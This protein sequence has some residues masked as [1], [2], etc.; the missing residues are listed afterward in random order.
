MKYVWDTENQPKLVR[1]HVQ[2]A[3]PEKLLIAVYDANKPVYYHKHLTDTVKGKDMFEISLPLTPKRA[4]FEITRAENA[5]KIIPD[6]G[7]SGIA[8]SIEELPFKRPC[9]FTA[10]PILNSFMNFSSWFA[11]NAAILSA[12]YGGNSSSVYR[13]VNGKFQIRYFQSIR[14]EQPYLYLGDA[15]L[16][17]PNFGKPTP[18]SFRIHTQTKE[19]NAAKDFVKDYTVPEIEVLLLHEFAH[20]FINRNPDDEMEADRNAITIARCYGFGKREIA[21][22]F[23]KV[24]MRYSSDEN[25]ERYE[26]VKQQLKNMP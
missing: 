25:V 19:M 14:D 7:N 1:L 17:N 18:T 6:F 9:N 13:S 16:P 21:N 2:T 22:A 20:G 10:Q 24:F 3:Q 4:F 23:Y 12:G 5:N 15:K 11:Q 26:A 8:Y